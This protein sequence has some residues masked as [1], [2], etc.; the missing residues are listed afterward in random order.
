[1]KAFY[2]GLLII[3]LVPGCVKPYL[4][5]A[6]AEESSLLVVD[7]NIV[8]GSSM[9]VKIFRTKS[10]LD[11]LPATPVTAASVTLESASGSSFELVA[12]D[13]GTYVGTGATAI[14]KYRLHLNADGK[15]YLSEYVDTKITPPIDSI[16]WKEDGDVFIYVDTHDDQALTR[17]YMWDFEETTEYHAVFDSNI[18]FRNGELIFITPEEMRFA[19]FRHFP[20]TTVLLGTSKE[21]DRDVISN[22]LLTRIVN[23]NS[24]INF[25]YSILVKQYALSEAA[26]R[27][28]KIIKQ[29]SEESGDLFDPQPSQLHGNIHNV[30]DPG[31]VVVG[32]L[33]ISTSSEKRLFISQSELS[34]IVYPD[35]DFCKE[36]FIRPEQAADL[37]TDPGYMGAYYRMS[38]G[39]LAVAPAKCVDCRLSG[40]TTERPSYW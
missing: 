4:P 27:Y 1:M 39:A 11:T 18:D 22:F 31:E 29:N 38:D 10:L 7:A 5:P 28:W 30:G 12:T 15:E 36:F 6:A 20:S 16:Y 2:F 13:P 33:N 37:L 26:Y 32:Y 25:R 21:L 23:D 24:K 35:I 3:V 17:Y 8:I 34:M 40:G 19:C 14:E 9:K